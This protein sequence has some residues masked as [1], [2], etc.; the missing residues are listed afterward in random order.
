MKMHVKWTIRAGSV[1]WEYDNTEHA[2]RELFAAWVP[3]DSIPIET[4]LAAG[5]R[6]GRLRYLRVR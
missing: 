3:P 5:R 4:P 2:N 1:T 6:R